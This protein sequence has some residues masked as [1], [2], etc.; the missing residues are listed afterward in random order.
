MHYP[1]RPALGSRDAEGAQHDDGPDGPTIGDEGHP[2]A[3]RHAT[4]APPPGGPHPLRPPGLPEHHHPGD[5]RARGGGPSTCCSGSSAR[6]PPSSARRWWCPSPRSSTTSAHGGSPS[7]PTRPGPTRSLEAFLGCALRPVR[8]EPGPRHDPL[9]RRCPHRRGAG[10]DRHRRHRPVPRRA[11]ADSAA[12]A[13]TSSA[14][15]STRHDLAARSTVALVAGMAAFG[16]TFFGGTRP[17]TRTH[18]RRD[19]PSHSARLP[20]PTRPLRDHTA[21]NMHFAGHAATVHR[22]HR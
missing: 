22:C 14:W 17:P 16:A 12:R 8:G 4:T 9:G 15:P 6:R 10:G 18:R 21:P 11:R 19:H 13:S 20:P 2:S 3:P 5:R 7:C 1:M